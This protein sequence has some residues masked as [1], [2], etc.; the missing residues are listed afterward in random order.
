MHRAWEQGGCGEEASP[1]TEQGA[2]RHRGWQGP[3]YSRPGRLRS[4]LQPRATHLLGRED[5]GGREEL[6]RG[7]SVRSPSPTD[8]QPC[9][10]ETWRE[11]REGSKSPEGCCGQPGRTRLGRGGGENRCYRHAQTCSRDQDPWRQEGVGTTPG[12]LSTLEWSPRRRRG[13]KCLTRIGHCQ[14]GHREK[15]AGVL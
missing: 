8:T 1:T 7:S 9:P 6:R 13:C 15:T 10:E 14:A 3:E 2:R 5:V 11:R 12:L 4:R